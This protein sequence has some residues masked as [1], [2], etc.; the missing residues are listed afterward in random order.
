MP[1]DINIAKNLLTEAG[2]PTYIEVAKNK[3]GFVEVL[4]RIRGTE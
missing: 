3:K 1:H 2:R 4:R